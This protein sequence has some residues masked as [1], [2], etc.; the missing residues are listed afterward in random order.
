MD[1]T[2]TTLTLSILAIASALAYLG[3]AFLQ[4]S[5]LKKDDQI[6]NPK[7]PSK[8]MLTQTLATA[9]VMMHGLVLWQQIIIEDQVQFN[10]ITISSLIAL[11]FASWLIANGFYRPL[12]NLYLYLFPFAALIIAVSPF[13][14]FDETAST[15]SA[16][17]ITHILLSTIAYSIL[18]LATAQS[19]L[20]N[21]QMSQLK[22]K[23]ITPLW[24]AMPPL[25]TMERIT[26]ELLITGFILLTA[27]MV[28]G[29]DYISL[30]PVPSLLHKISFTVLAWAT[31]GILIVGHFT[32]GWRGQMMNR[33]ILT[34]FVILILGF[35]GSRWLLQFIYNA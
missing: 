11:F 9:A 15:L 34:S 19:A 2:M 10:V 30:N 31:Y 14:H 7:K 5:L 32:R 4:L 13:I 8:A 20:V 26:H 28:S 29:L 25:Q 35:F 16:G 33:W 24:L 17:L 1:R 12:R 22:N 27:A 6:Q 23:K 21:H 3:S 18:T